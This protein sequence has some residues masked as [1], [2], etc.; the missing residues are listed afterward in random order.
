MRI[1][2][3][4]GVICFDTDDL[5]E[6]RLLD[7][8]AAL[9]AEIGEARAAARIAQWLSPRDDAYGTATL[10]DV[11]DLSRRIEAGEWRSV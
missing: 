10:V 7:D 1:Y 3:M 8:Y 2:Q 11:C 9:C 5:N 6:A 4:D